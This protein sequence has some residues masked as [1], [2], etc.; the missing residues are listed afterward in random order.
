MTKA[1]DAL[2]SSKDSGTE[3][4]SPKIGHEDAY[5]TC[6]ASSSDCDANMMPGRRLEQPMSLPV[7]PSGQQQPK[8]VQVSRQNRGP[9]QFSIDSYDS[10]DRTEMPYHQKLSRTGSFTGPGGHG[11]PSLPPVI[12]ESNTDSDYEESF[13][14]EEPRQERRAEPEPPKIDVQLR[15]E[16]PILL[17]LATAGKKK[18]E[19]VIKVEKDKFQQR[20]ASPRPSLPARPSEEVRQKAAAS[21]SKN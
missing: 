8:F 17:E 5:S 2:S 9:M 18:E 16:E 4:S 20:E 1:D 11:K 19:P 14:A 10:R 13:I 6:S 21:T 7:H 3:V 12:K 15:T